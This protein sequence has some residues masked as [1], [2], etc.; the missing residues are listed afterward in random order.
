M[1]SF[2][3]V[4]DYLESHDWVLYRIDEPYRVFYHYGSPATGLPILVEV[5]NKMVDEDHFANLRQVVE[6]GEREDD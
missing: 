1:P 3:Q 6:G 2:A 4:L 5:H